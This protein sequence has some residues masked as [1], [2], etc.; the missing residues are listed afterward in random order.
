MTGG[1]MQTKLWSGALLIAVGAAMSAAKVLG[2]TSA[3]QV[4]VMFTGCVQRAEPSRETSTTKYLLTDVVVARAVA[5]GTSG[6][7]TT[8]APDT[9]TAR[10]TA[11]TDTTTIAVE[12]VDVAPEYRLDGDDAELLRHMDQKVEITGSAPA[13]FAPYDSSTAVENAPTLAVS[14]IRT[15]ASNCR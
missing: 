6:S 3:D 14:A 8:T 11:P 9:T 4:N 5:V 15:I 7:T 1:S 12:Q 10:T 2:E 13:Q